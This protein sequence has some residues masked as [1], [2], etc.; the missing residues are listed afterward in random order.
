M[1]AKRFPAATKEKL[2]DSLE[3]VVERLISKYALGQAIW[4]ETWTAA[5]NVA[6]RAHDGTAVMY[7]Q[8]QL[9]IMFGMP[10]AI[11]GPENY[12]WFLLGTE[13]IP[14]EQDLERGIAMAIENLSEQKAAQLNGI[15]KPL[16]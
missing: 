11:L 14:T 12:V 2:G 13:P 1:P 6:R 8:P 9:Q 3:A 10:G 4:W 5:V 15:R 7:T 16:T